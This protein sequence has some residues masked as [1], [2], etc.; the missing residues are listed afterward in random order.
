M[1]EVICPRRLGPYSEDVSVRKP[2]IPMRMRTPRSMRYRLKIMLKK[3]PVASV[4]TGRLCVAI[5]HAALRVAIKEKKE[6]HS[7]VSHY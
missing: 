2:E 7:E 5:G 3:G 6:N 1:K 4:S